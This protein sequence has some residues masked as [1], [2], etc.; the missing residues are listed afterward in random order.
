MSLLDL[1]IKEL[2]EK[3]SSK[4]IT[5]TELTQACFDRI[6]ETDDQVNAFLTLNKE[7][8]L[9]EAMQLDE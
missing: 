2:Q 5:V 7:A 3:L 1:T 8:A 9:E 4:E 6:E